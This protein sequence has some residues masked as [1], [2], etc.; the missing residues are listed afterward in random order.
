MK[1]GAAVMFKGKEYKV[2]W[3]YS[4]GTCEIKQ[5]DVIGK[6]ELV[7]LSEVIAL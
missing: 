2:I 7:A 5:K 4:N 6:V 1:S 3:I